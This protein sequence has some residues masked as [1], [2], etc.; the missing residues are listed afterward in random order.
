MIA[1]A[2]VWERLGG[3]GSRPPNEQ[4]TSR[5][6]RPRTVAA[7]EARSRLGLPPTTSDSSEV[8]RNG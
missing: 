3:T 6:E 5:Q 2:F 7:A 1:A 8:I 4:E